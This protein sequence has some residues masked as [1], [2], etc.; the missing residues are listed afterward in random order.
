MSKI[1]LY[2]IF[3]ETF[4]GEY[5][6]KE[7]DGFYKLFLG[8]GEKKDMVKDVIS[9]KDNKDLKLKNLNAFKLRG[10]AIRLSGFRFQLEQMDME[11]LEDLAFYLYEGSSEGIYEYIK[12]NADT[13]INN[14][15]IIYGEFCEFYALRGSNV[16]ACHLDGTLTPAGYDKHKDLL[17]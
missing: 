3:S 6:E 8:E 14:T 12:D 11:D 4:R 7:E 17:D 2:E 13:K 5:W 9:E 10:Y 15:Y 16:Y 1:Y